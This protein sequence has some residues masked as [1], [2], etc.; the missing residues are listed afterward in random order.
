MPPEELKNL[1]DEEKFG[2]IN[3]KLNC[4]FCHSKN[5]VRTSLFTYSIEGL[6]SEDNLLKRNDWRNSL[7][8]AFFNPK[9][10]VDP[11]QTK[12]TLKAHCMK[13]GSHWELFAPED[14]GG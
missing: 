3:E 9:E 8:G 5:C 7:I 14:N 12:E 13:C 2:P 11:L 10:Y 6:F 1:E 4:I